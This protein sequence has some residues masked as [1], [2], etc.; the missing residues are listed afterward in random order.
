MSKVERGGN[1]L[2]PCRKIKNVEIHYNC[3]YITNI[4]L[5][6]QNFLIAQTR[7]NSKWA[8]DITVRPEL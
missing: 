7:I 4:Q 6:K 5:K 3:E 2:V 1:G 8:T